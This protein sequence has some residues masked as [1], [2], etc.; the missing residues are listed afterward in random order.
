MAYILG[1]DAGTTSFKAALFNDT[2]KEIASVREEY[3]LLTPSDLMVELAPE[4]YW[5]IFKSVVGKTLALV[6]KEQSIRPEKIIALA[7]DS[8]GETLI[9]LD[10]NG[11]PLRNAI[12]WLDNRSY[13]ETEKIREKYSAK[14][15][16]DI[17]GQPEIIPTWPVTKIMWLKENEPDVFK[18][19]FKYVLL[20]DYLI[21][22]LTGEYAGE[23]S[24]YSSSLML[25]I[26]KG[27]WWEDMLEFA[28]I[29]EK[30]LPKIMGSG[31]AVGRLTKKTADETGIYVDTIVVTGA[32]DQTAGII[33]AC[34]IKPGT[35]T[36][37]T[38]SCLA[39][40]ANVDKPVP[41][42]EDLLIPCQYHAIDGK[43]YLMLWSQSAG[44]VLE[45]L[46]DN[47]Y[48]MEKDIGS[49]EKNIYSLIDQQ[50]E[51]VPAGCEGLIM[52]PFLS[53]AACPEFNHNA[54]GVFYGVTLNHKK[55]HFARSVMEAV[56]FNLKR[57]LDALE[58][59]GVYT[60]HIKSMGGGAKSS[61]W[62][63]IKADITQK[64]VYACK[65]TETACLGAAILAGIGSGIFESIEKACSNIKYSYRVYNPRNNL[66]KIY[67]KS[68]SKYIM[69]YESLKEQFK[70]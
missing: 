56:A 3:S 12:V 66:K 31:Q 36:E 11:K 57:N 16:Y 15:V 34:N 55:P 61:F 7:I 1:I 21:Y 33:G 6:Y 23:K 50:A 47:F 37:T 17:T 8:Q 9:C 38:G 53:G 52:L 54:K 25:D 41:F 29:S 64:T 20:E 40:C 62:N 28:E 43:Y 67:N 42:N 30:Q 70:K 5:K 45:W 2:G 4:V 27:I 63:Q 68:Y 26:H 13:R 24:L 49:Y 58:K 19:T 59:L 60:D 35:V 44:M 39:V 18:N 32:L 51:D 22:R 10:K 65:N 48:N 14:Y 46:K 69:L